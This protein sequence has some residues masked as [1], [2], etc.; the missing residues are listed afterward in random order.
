V[1][2]DDR[3]APA[4]LR[5]RGDGSWGAV[6]F[7]SGTTPDPE[8]WWCFRF[9][10]HDVTRSYGTSPVNVVID[11]VPLPRRSWRDLAGVTATG[12][13][14]GE[15]IETTVYFFEHHMY[16]RV[17]LRAVEQDADDPRRLRVAATVA[18]DVDGLGI[19]DFTVDA[20]LTFS[21]IALALDRPAGSVEEATGLLAAHTPTDGLV[22]ESTPQG[23]HF[24]PG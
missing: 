1:D 4:E 13:E 23:F 8:L 24:A 15:P 12:D 19:E 22:A 11:W 7:S 18:E 17:E 16:D 6:L 9:E 21:G 20:W 2:D 5:P 10:H 3:L 14:F